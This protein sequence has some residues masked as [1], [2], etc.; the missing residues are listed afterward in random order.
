MRCR[1]RKDEDEAAGADS[2]LDESESEAEAGAENLKMPPGT[3][4]YVT[5]ADMAPSGIGGCQKTRIKSSEE[6][7]GA[8]SSLSK[9]TADQIPRAFTSLCV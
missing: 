8:V 5:T 4:S 9:T 1:A 3:Y 6:V 7:G 2:E